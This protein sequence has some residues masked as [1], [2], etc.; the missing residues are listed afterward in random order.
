MDALGAAGWVRGGGRPSFSEASCYPQDIFDEAKSRASVF[1]WSI[2]AGN[3]AQDCQSIE[4]SVQKFQKILTN[5]NA[6]KYRNLGVM[7]DVGIMTWHLRS[8]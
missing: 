6:K 1:Q 8:G 5:E 2:L 4:N 7:R 3:S